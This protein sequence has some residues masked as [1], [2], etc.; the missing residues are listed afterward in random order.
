[1][2]YWLKELNLNI[3]G[4]IIQN[5]LKTGNNLNY[6]LVN[7]KTNC[8]VTTQWRTLFKSK[9]EKNPDTLMNLKSIMLNETN[10]TQKTTNCVILFTW[11]SHK[12]NKSIVTREWMSG[13]QGLE[14]RKKMD[15][16]GYMCWQ[17]KNILYYACG[18]GCMIICIC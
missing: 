7:G 10:Q 13:F 17:I 3:P 4:S 14:T 5:N 9:K 15:Y 18:N 1:M 12:A 8:D 6:Q 16:L 2:T 11:N